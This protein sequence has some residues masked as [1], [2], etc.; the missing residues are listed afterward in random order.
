MTQTEMIY[1]TVYRVYRIVVGNIMFFIFLAFFLL[2]AGLII[3]FAIR[4][5]NVGKQERVMRIASLSMGFILY[6]VSRQIIFSI[7]HFMFYKYG[8]QTKANLMAVCIFTFLFSILFVV[9]MFLTLRKGTNI[10]S[11]IGILFGA[12]VITLFIDTF[13]TALSI[14]GFRQPKLF[15]P[16]YVFIVGL[17]LFIILIFDKE[18][19]KPPDDGGDDKNLPAV[20]ESD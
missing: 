10:P 15:I 19:Q 3:K 17:V 9:V 4:K 2:L 8:L 12:W 7:P 13:V 5:K 16:N 14:G 1:P 20:R 6:Y 11:R 18:E